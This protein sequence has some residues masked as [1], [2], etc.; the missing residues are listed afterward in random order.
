[1]KLR[2]RQLGRGDAFLVGGVQTAVAEVVQDGAGEQ[3]ASWRTM[4]R[5]RREVP[6]R[7]GGWG[8]RREA[9]F[10]RR[11]CRRSG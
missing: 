4:P 5:E 10:C 1:M 3:A 9:G 7:S 6:F 2:R 8:C 11:R